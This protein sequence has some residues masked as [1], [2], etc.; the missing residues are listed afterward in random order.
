MHN[1]LTRN[2]ARKRKSSERSGSRRPVAN[3]EN[4]PVKKKLKLPCSVF[5]ETNH[6]NL[7]GC[8]QFKRYLP[9]QPSKTRSLPKD[10]CRL[11]LGTIYCDCRHNGMRDYQD[12]M[13]KV[14]K[15]NFIICSTCKKH[16]RAH[17][18]LRVNH[19]PSVGNNNIRFMRRAIGYENL[20]V[21]T[22]RIIADTRNQEKS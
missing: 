15:R 8:P 2:E 9:G 19:D 11:C 10:V 5:A 12:Y 7:L 4:T 22:I 17:H 20:Q 21:N 3:E 14:S 18:W 6:S 13:C 1:E 16:E